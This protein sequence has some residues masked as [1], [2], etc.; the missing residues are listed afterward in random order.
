MAQ[1]ISSY[2]W[3]L[4]FPFSQERHQDYCPQDLLHQEGC[5]QEGHQEDCPQE[6]RQGPQEGCPQEAHQGRRQEVILMN[7][8]KSFFFVN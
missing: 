5:P 7:Y 2:D 4:T 3:Y 8:L 1:E 6:S